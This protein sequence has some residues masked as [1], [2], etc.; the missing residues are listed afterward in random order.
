[1]KTGG[2]KL[3]AVWYLRG[4]RKDAT[5]RQALFVSLGRLRMELHY[6]TRYVGRAAAASFLP[7]IETRASRIGS[8]GK[9]W[10]WEK[11]N[12]SRLQTSLTYACHSTT[13]SG[14]MRRDKAGVRGL[15]G[16]RRA[17]VNRCDSCA[18]GGRGALWRRA[19]RF[20]VC[21]SRLKPAA[22][23][24]PDPEQ[25]LTGGRRL[26]SHTHTTCGTVMMWAEALQNL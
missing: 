16:G 15:R 1:M 8:R 21:F 10:V 5:R 2:Q 24:W 14:R 11:K 13:R 3:P 12:V 25:V 26:I 19:A 18:I 20:L 23:P 9:T 22:A 4:R 6:L 7:L 17:T